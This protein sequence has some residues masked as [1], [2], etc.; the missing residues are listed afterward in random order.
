M[1]LW[2]TARYRLDSE[3]RRMPSWCSWLGHDGGRLALSFGFF[4]DMRHRFEQAANEKEAHDLAAAPVH[5]A[6]PTS[7]PVHC[8]AWPRKISGVVSWLSRNAVCAIG[9]R[10]KKRRVSKRLDI[11]GRHAWRDP[12]VTRP[13]GLLLEFSVR[14]LLAL[15]AVQPHNKTRLHERVLIRALP[16]AREGWLDLFA[17]RP[18]L[19][20]E[21][22][23]ASSRFPPGN[24]KAP[25]QVFRVRAPFQQ[26][27]LHPCVTFAQQNH[28]GCVAGR[29]VID[30]G[31]DFQR[32]PIYAVHCL[33][34]DN[35]QSGNTCHG[36]HGLK[37][38]RQKAIRSR[39]P[40]EH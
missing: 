32:D 7:Y 1:A 29:R 25:P 26:Q 33:R 15:H 4:H 16:I 10:A 38:H 35:C 13:A 12:T 3:S 19:W 27:D 24:T 28:G 17:K 14:T 22:R 5:F 2:G 6:M 31:G 20:A 36:S 8:A 23:L 34:S 39:N 11:R 18:R 40:N 37:R 30:V 21:L 9:A